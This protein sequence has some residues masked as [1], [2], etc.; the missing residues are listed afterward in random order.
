[1]ASSSVTSFVEQD[2]PRS[3]ESPGM[4]IQLRTWQYIPEDSELHTRCRDNLKSH[5]ANHVPRNKKISKIDHWKY[6]EAY[7]EWG[8][9]CTLD[10]LQPLSVICGVTLSN[11]SMKP[12]LLQRHFNSYHNPM[13]GK[14]KD[15][16][17]A[18]RQ[19][20]STQQATLKTNDCIQ[21][22]WWK[23]HGTLLHLQWW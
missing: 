16:F 14:S 3:A 20:L 6:D 5:K 7:I 17:N 1:M 4:Y 15:F 18:K 22:V 23:M 10:G 11:H 13:K 8:F 9:S 12:S 19:D 2:K 21:F